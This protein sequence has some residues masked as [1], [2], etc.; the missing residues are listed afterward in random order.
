M[1]ERRYADII[2]ALE[3]GDERVDVRAT[4][5]YQDGTRIERQITLPIRC[6]LAPEALAGRR[7]R[8]AWSRRA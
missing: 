4:V 6:P 1:I 7:Q 2:A 8:P 5:T 3:R